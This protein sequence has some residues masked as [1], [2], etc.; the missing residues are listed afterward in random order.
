MCTCNSLG[1]PLAAEKAEGPS[2][3]LTFL[4]ITKDTVKMLEPKLLRIR[5]TVQGWLTKRRAKKREILSLLG[6]LQHTTKVVNI[7]EQD[8]FKLLHR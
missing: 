4:E 8:V 3:T 5:H 1:V 6:L 7:C 2:T